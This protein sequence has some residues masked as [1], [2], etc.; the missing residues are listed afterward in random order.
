MKRPRSATDSDD[1]TPLFSPSPS[2]SESECEDEAIDTSL[3]RSIGS[4]NLGRTLLLK[5]GWR[6]GTGLGVGGFGR[7]DPV[8]IS[9]KRGGDLTGIGKMS[10]DT[11]T[12]ESSTANRR[13][14][15]SERQLNETEAEREIRFITNE[16]KQAQKEDVTQALKTYRC[17]LC[18]KQ[19]DRPSS[20]EAHLNSYDHHHKKVSQKCDATRS[21]LKSVNAYSASWK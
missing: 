14:L 18:Q 5:M 10:L 16:K 9:D 6:E 11:R 8:P 12:I 2:K 3:Y 17:D 21:T 1:E 13:F 4:G 20:F 15:E 7:V 19:Y